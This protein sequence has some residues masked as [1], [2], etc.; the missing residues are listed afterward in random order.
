MNASSPRCDGTP[1]VVELRRRRR[2]S[3]FVPFNRRWR[4]TVSVGLALASVDLGTKWWATT[5]RPSTTTN[6]A[7]MLGLS[8][9][10]GATLASAS[11]VI[12]SMLMSL[13]ALAMRKGMQAIWSA[14]ILGGLVGNLTDRLY[15]GG[16]HD[17]LVVGHVEANLA[18][19]FLFVAIPAV[20]A[21]LVVHA[22]RAPT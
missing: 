18:D 20:I 21:F 1:R 4:F 6:R 19:G 10:N 2:F 14:L 12:A 22:G 3:L 15:T 5:V 17:W 8:G 9:L 16:V 13:S 7:M 11:L